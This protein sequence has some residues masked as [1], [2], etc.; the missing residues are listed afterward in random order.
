MK[1]QLPRRHQWHPGTTERGV[2]NLWEGRRRGAGGREEG[3][4]DEG[5]IVGD[6]AQPT[7]TP[8]G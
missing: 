8:P 7:W 4:K 1:L 3:D 2:A 6:R 5:A